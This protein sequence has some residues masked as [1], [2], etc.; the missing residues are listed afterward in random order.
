MATVEI[1]GKTKTISEDWISKNMEILD[2]TR[3]Q[4]IQ[5][6]LEDEGY[7]VNEV[8]EELTKKAKALPRKNASSGKERKKATRERK[9]DKE[10]ERIVKIIAEALENAGFQPKI[11]NSAKIIEFSVDSTSYKVDLIKKRPKKD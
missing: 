6:W 4:A 1:N 2:I 3:E 7:E 9:P 5:M 10:K 8:V 11:V